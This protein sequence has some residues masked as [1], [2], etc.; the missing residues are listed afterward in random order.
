MDV[1][2]AYLLANYCDT[3][4]FVIKHGY[5]PKNI[6][7]YILSSGE[8]NSISDTMILYNG[9]KDQFEGAS[10]NRILGDIKSKYTIGSGQ[11][12]LLN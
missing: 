6:V 9:V 2:D 12:K 5:T 1:A 3:T 8:I 4:L 10:R 7:E 11:V